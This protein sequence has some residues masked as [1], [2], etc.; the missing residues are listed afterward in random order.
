A[1][2]APPA[3]G[4]VV[5]PADG[6]IASPFVLTNGY[7]YQSVQTTDPTLGGSAVFNFV[8]TNSGSYTISG[9]VNALSDA[10]NSFYV[11]IDAEPTDPMMIWDI[12]LTSGF[13]NEA[14]S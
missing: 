11:N 14:V 10:A 7:I 5:L 3:T 1:S 4:L 13:A 9:Y 6:I 2:N 8:I 12:P